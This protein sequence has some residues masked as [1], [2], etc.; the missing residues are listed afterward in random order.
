MSLWPIL[1]IDCRAPAADVPAD[2]PAPAHPLLDQLSRETQD[3][4]RGLRGSVLRVQMPPPRWLNDPAARDGQ[5][6]RKYKN[7]NPDVRRTL[8]QQQ[9]R[10]A[11]P[12]P[13]T[14]PLA[15]GPVA[16]P[17]AQ[18]ATDA[19]NDY[20]AQG[21]VIVVPPPPAP[22]AT[23]PQV[24]APAAPAA[25]PPL[26]PNN[27]GLVLDDQGHVLVPLYVEREAVADQPIRLV[28]TDGQ[29]VEAKFVG[30]DQQTNLTVLQLPPAPAK[31]PAK[32]ADG[33]KAGD[34][35]VNRPVHQPVD[36]AVDKPDE[37]PAVDDEQPAIKP[38]RLAKSKPADGSLVLYVS[39]NDAAGRLGVWSNN[40]RD[41]G[42]VVGVDGQVL[43]IARYGQFLGGGAC[44]LIA[45]QIIR[46]GAVK[47]AT[48][49]V[50]ITQI[51]KDDPLR[52][53]QPALADRPAVR[54]DQVMK[55]SAAERGGLRQGDVVL[56]LAGEPVGDIPALSAAV[57]ARNGH[58]PLRV[59]RAGEVIEVVVDLERR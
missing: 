22:A 35:A 49:G 58:T 24:A 4:Y 45:D 25:P 42:V 13:T 38:V 46:H 7:L 19:V 55:G 17:G 16:G 6:D 43:G 44:Q 51:E 20:A 9:Q 30:S 56:A 52:A 3:L 27:I 26:A 47:R 28:G 2:R 32:P 40:G 31:G 54:V 8:E 48:L 1:L 39:P 34:K 14:Q 18:T 33:E 29:V 41:Y 53:A 12:G 36:K 5:W 50:I 37:K 57:A 23:P 10:Y 11:S 59:L 21:V 15:A